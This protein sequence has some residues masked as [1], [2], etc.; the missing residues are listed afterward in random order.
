MAV[1]AI[2]EGV[3]PRKPEGAKRLGFSEELWRMV[4]LCWLEDRDERP[5]IEDIV[6]CLNGAVSFWYMREY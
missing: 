1:N 2:V 4:E 3:R 5:G 6:S